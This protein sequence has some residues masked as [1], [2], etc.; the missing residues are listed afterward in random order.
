VVEERIKGGGQGGK[1]FLDLCLLSD[2]EDP[3]LPHT[4]R[5]TRVREGG[6]GVHLEKQSP[7]RGGYFM[8]ERPPKRKGKR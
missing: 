5:K 1:N 3:S 2:K 8:G 7:N 6:R 4:I